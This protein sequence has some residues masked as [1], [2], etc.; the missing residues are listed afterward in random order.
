[1]S[2]SGRVQGRVSYYDDEEQFDENEY[3]V[4][5]EEAGDASWNTYAVDMV[6]E[7][8]LGRKLMA[9][10]EDDPSALEE[11]FYIKWRKR[12]YLHAS[13]ERRADIEA[14]DPNGKMKL[15]KFMLTPMPRGIK[16]EPLLGDETIVPD[17][18]GEGDGDEIAADF[19]GEEIDY[20]DPDMVEVQRILNCS[21]ATV[22]H[23][24][25]KTVEDIINGSSSRKG[26]EGFTPRTS[27]KSSKRENEYDE[28][29]SDD[30]TLQLIGTTSGAEGQ[31][32]DP[33]DEILYLVK[34]QALPY[35][36]CTW[37][38]WGDLKPF[39]QEVFE[40]W[41]RQK[42]PK[43]VFSA[44]LPHPHVRD[45]QKLTVSPVFGSTSSSSSLS[46]S[47]SAAAL[48]SS[49]S[50]TS[51]AAAVASASASASTTGAAEAEA[52][53]DSASAS[54]SAAGVDAGAG[55]I[56]SGSATAS[57]AAEGEAESTGLRL[58]DYQLEGVNWL[59][60]NWWNRRSCILADEMGLGECFLYKHTVS[61][62]QS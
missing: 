24:T 20:F 54:S 43:E 53:S 14:V 40:F 45:Y 4:P 52:D 17:E 30:E 5:A 9:S 50:T 44:P 7:K 25:A 37:E 49:S 15:K 19:D 29:G 23:A 28:D 57:T 26:K 6:V 27:R 35:S 47:R 61:S 12:S 39:A 46:R 42:P 41:Q 59:M 48:K 8:V 32:E 62:R 58:R 11:Y 38:R 60:W 56:A 51:L 3:L 10:D 18:D 16:G 13:W 34:W 31:V 33:E 2:R 55:A 22:S 21:T 1:M 36:E